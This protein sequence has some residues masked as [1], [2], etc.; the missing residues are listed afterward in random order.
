MVEK[1]QDFQKLQP[2]LNGTQLIFLDESGFRLG[3]CSRYGWAPKGKDAK[4]KHVQCTW[5]TLT[6]VGA[7]GLDGVRGF[8]TVDSGTSR[9]VFEAFIEQQL[10]PNL[11][12]G[13]IVV[14]DNLA[15]HKGL[16]VRQMLEKVG[17]SILFTPPYCPEF[18]PIEKMWAKLKGIIRRADTLTRDSFDFAV[19]SAL[20]SISL[21]DIRAWTLHAGY[22]LN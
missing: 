12:P 7:I 21:H 2:T 14:M 11:N 8:M 20:D 9:D 6:M 15:A 16:K 3:D 18:N 1:R 22:Q 13:D 19:A 10:V 4:G 17:A 5:K